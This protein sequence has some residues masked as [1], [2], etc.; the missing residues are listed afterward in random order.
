MQVAIV[1]LKNATHQFI[2]NPKPMLKAL[3][4]VL[5]WNDVVSDFCLFLMPFLW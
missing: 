1:N 4:L 3:D 5:I 2:L